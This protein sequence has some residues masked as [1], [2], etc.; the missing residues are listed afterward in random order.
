ML[1]DFFELEKKLVDQLINLKEN[2]ELCVV[3]AEFEAEGASLR[4]LFKLRVLTAR[5]DVP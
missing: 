4:D 5:Y 1:H 2:F 3:K